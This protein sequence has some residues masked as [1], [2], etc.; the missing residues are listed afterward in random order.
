MLTYELEGRGD[1][2]LYEYLYRCIRGDILNG[3]L[4]P[5]TR[6]PSKRALAEHLGVSVIT[7]ETAYQ[8]LEAEGCVYAQ[9]R[10]GFFV[11]QVE[12]LPK[13]P[14][15]AVRLPEQ[16]PAPQWRLDLKQNRVDVRCFPVSAWVRLTRQVL[17]EGGAALLSPVPQ[18]GLPALRSAIARDLRERKGMAVSPEQIVVGAGAEYLYLLLAQL[19]GRETVLAVEDPG[20]PK[21]RQ[22][23][24]KWGLPCRPVTLDRQGIDPKAL[25][26]AGAAAAPGVELAKASWSWIAA[27]CITASRRWSAGWRSW[28]SAAARPAGLG[29]KAGCPSSALWAT[30]TWANP[31]CSTPCA[32]PR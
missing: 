31:A 14:S 4:L 5:H 21:I 20:Y 11:S 6:L 7:V 10:R 3:T 18:Q 13:A 24:E 12:R 16:P 30:P 25:T 26:A 27:M 29:R 1:L 28:K 19:L 9:P 32:G 22:V 23:Y 17:S 8:Q 15:A 2:P